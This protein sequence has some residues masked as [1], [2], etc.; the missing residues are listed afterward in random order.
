MV[1]DPTK[2]YSKETLYQLT[3]KGRKYIEDSNK[4][5][6]KLYYE[7]HKHIEKETPS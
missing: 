2:V 6:G 7:I 3:D 5:M 4:F 1:K